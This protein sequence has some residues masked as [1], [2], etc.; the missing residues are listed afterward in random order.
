MIVWGIVVAAGS[1]DRF[2]GPKQRAVLAGRPLWQ[3]AREALLAGGVSRVV[4]V[5]DVDGGIPGGARRQDSVAVGLA[6]LPDEVTHVLVHD[7]A[8]PLASAGLVRSVVA[9]LSAGSEAVVPAVP[10]RD[11]IKRVAAGRVVATVD[12]SGLVAVQTPQGFAVEVLRRAHGAVT[13]DVTDDA[14]MVEA[15]GGA[16]DI[17]P[18]EAGNIKVTFPEDLTHAAALLEVER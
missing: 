17:V 15:I 14:S 8:R 6:E 1:G 13:G 11:T 3:W 5:G 7:A 12:R 9:A 18:G 16:V 10:V 2:G 4:V